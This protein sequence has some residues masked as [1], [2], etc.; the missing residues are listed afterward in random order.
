MHTLAI[1]ARASAW[2][3]DVRLL[4]R[5]AAMLFHYV[6]AGGRLRRLY[7]RLE[8]R[9]EVYWVDAGGATVHRE[10]ALRRR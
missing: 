8:A 4:S 9:G 6:T 5:M 3:R 7:R 1:R 2:R 10:E